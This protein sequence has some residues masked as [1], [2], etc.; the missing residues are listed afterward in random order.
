MVIKVSGGGHIRFAA[1]PIAHIVGEV[2][3]LGQGVVSVGVEL[4]HAAVRCRRSNG[5]LSLALSRIKRCSEYIKKGSA[6]GHWRD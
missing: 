3:K 2:N 6:P 4:Q 1:A 5:V